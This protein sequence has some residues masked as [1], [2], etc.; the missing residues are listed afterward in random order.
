MLINFLHSCFEPDVK[1]DSVTTEGYEISNLTSSDSVLSNKGFLAERFISSP[2]EIKIR[3]VCP[4][5]IQRIVI[6][7][8]V[9]NQKSLGFELS[10]GNALSSDNRVHFKRFA[11][12]VIPDHVGGVVFE[13]EGSKS[14]QTVD[15]RISSFH[16]ATFYR[17][18]GYENVTELLVKIF[19][20]QYVAAVKKIEIW[21]IPH[22]SCN[23][24]T[25][26]FVYSTWNKSQKNHIEV[27]SAQICDN[28]N[29]GVV[30]NESSIS[31]D[32]IP[33][34]FC[35]EITREIMTLPMILPSGKVVDYRTLEKFQNEEAGWGRS[36]SDPFTGVPFTAHRKPIVATSLKLNIDSFCARN[37]NLNDIKMLPRRLGSRDEYDNSGVKISE[38][39]GTNQIH[40]RKLH[41]LT[42]YGKEE[43]C[44][45]YA[46]TKYPK[47]SSFLNSPD[48]GPSSTKLCS[49]CKM[50]KIS[51]SYKLPC[52][53]IICRN[54]LSTYQ[55][56][57]TCKLS[58]SSRDVEKIHIFENI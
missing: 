8:K 18:R 26:A 7:T 15:T 29:S 25:K 17:G 22:R 24:K 44:D 13:K 53:H 32:P 6:W 57:G 14:I 40:K 16:E 2:V 43:S 27:T 12:V 52:S 9:S 41:S 21:G 51:D 45:R 54:C 37:S 30:E 33:D 19:K 38:L 34:E 50:S 3:L 4:I 23:R 28:V 55:E 35:D 36:P 56:C 20:F 39:V 31:S 47:L 5:N 11:S 1:C 58:F 10:A 46:T 49:Q 42:Y 48:S